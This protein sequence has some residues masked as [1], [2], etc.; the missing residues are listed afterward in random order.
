M[1]LLL[2]SLCF[3]Q[4]IFKIEP[5]V[6]FSKNNISYLA[7][8]LNAP[9]LVRVKLSS[10]VR[11]SIINL[12]NRF[13]EKKFYKLK[14][15]KLKCDRIY[16]FEVKVEDSKYHKMEVISHPC[17]EA[18][19]LKFL[20]ITDTQSIKSNPRLGYSRHRN[21]AKAVMDKLEDQDVNFAVHAGDVVSK[22]GNSE[23]WLKFFDLARMYLEKLPMIAALGNHDYHGELEEGNPQNFNKYL[24]AKPDSLLG[25]VYLSFPQV[26]LL[27]H[28][29][30]YEHLSEK[31]IQ[32]QFKWIERK[33]LKAKL[34]SKKVILVSHH[35]AF[36]STFGHI[37]KDTKYIRKKLLPIIEKSGNIPLV[38]SGHVHT[39]ERSEKD[40][41]VYLN[42]GSSGGIMN[43]SRYKNKYSKFLVR[44][45]P[46]YSLIEVNDKFINIETFDKKNELVEEHKINF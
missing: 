6:I 19:S 44:F 12:K 37:T 8:E 25:N 3:S 22:G 33:C 7:F 35:P 40:G 17:D 20:F 10:K 14:V 5:Y 41:I 42:G 30:N 34:V 28:N 2:S 4:N 13:E 32:E 36:S 9:S 39:Y 27:V 43:P 29:T 16:D 26:D 1:I 31:E 23:H 15:G 18:Q 46:T 45:K 11:Q 24:R 38:L 21:I